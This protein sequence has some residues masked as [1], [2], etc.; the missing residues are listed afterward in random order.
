MKAQ[1]LLI[2]L[3]FISSPVSFADHNGGPINPPVNPPVNPVQPVNINKLSQELSSV[4]VPFYFDEDKIS[5]IKE[6]AV[7]AVQ[8]TS[9][10]PAHRTE[11]KNWFRFT[12]HQG[13][14]YDFRNKTYNESPL[15]TLEEKV[16]QLVEN[17]INRAAL[18]YDPFHGNGALSVSGTF[19]FYRRGSW[20][21]P[22]YNPYP[23]YNP[24]PGPTWTRRSFSFSGPSYSAVLNECFQYVYEHH[25]DYIVAVELDRRY[26]PRPSFGYSQVIPTQEACGIVASGG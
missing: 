9:A 13:F 17:E 15:M 19:V 24:H 8:D 5:K 10:N 12:L 6:L 18:S 16:C 22:I 20:P 14:S 4:L 3:L 7:W 25:I 26:N 1:F 23:P 21:P 11:N 2:G